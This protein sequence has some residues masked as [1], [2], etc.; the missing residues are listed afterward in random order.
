AWKRTL[1][2]HCAGR[3]RR[4]DRESSA[5]SRD[6]IQLRRAKHACRTSDCY[7]EG[8]ALHVRRLHPAS[9]VSANLAE[10]G[11]AAAGD[12]RDRRDLLFLVGALSHDAVV[13]TS[14]DDE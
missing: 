9:S 10:L 5:E 14:L 8:T 3:D 11:S 2:P 7:R 1:G 12:A 4:T 6:R 13:E